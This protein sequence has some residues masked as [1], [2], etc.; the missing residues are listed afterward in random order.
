MFQRL[1]HHRTAAA[2]SAGA[3]ALA[4]IIGLAVGARATPA[5]R[6]SPPS[7]ASIAM[8]DLPKVLGGLKSAQAKDDALKAAEAELKKKAEAVKAEID[9]ER[10]RIG[11]LPDDV[12]KIADL[13]ALRERTLRADFDL[14]YGKAV[15]AEQQSEG[16]KELYAEIRTGIAEL[17]KAR[18]YHLV[19]SSDEGVPVRGTYDQA[20]QTIS[21]K[22]FF[23]VDPAMDI[24]DE[25][26]QY[27][28][29]QFA[30]GAN[31]K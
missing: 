19:I 21:L 30:T 20:S 6:F 18:G 24:T 29:N 23:Y 11:L 1:S 7:P 22:R 31:K 13:K 27:M 17:A 3:L 14:D 10:K 9:A 4:A 16:L 25:L 2:R 12:K 28:N 5:P 8:V 26:V 15:L